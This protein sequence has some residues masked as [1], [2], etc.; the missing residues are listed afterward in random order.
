MFGADLMVLKLW[1]CGMGF[2]VIFFSK[3]LCSSA[4]E[5]GW[6][7]AMMWVLRLGRGVSGHFWGQGEGGSP[8]KGGPGLD[9]PPKGGSL[10]IP[11]RKKVW[12]KRE[13]KFFLLKRER[14]GGWGDKKIFLFLFGGVGTRFREMWFL[15]FFSGGRGE[16]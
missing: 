13:N 2:P 16:L 12:E 9:P 4:E 1:G 7:R 5:K 11:P 8:R 6:F 3:V 10:L 15:I 14:R